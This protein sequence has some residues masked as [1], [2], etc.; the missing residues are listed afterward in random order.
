MTLHRRVIAFTTGVMAIG[1]IAMSA[2]FAQSPSQTIRVM[3]WWSTLGVFKG[4]WEY[5]MKE[6]ERQNPGVRIDYTAT[7]YDQTLNQ[8]MASTLANNA[9][10]MIQVSAVWFEQLRTAN[11]LEPLER[12]IPAEELK[13]FPPQLLEDAKVGGA[14]YGLP[15]APGPIM[16]I[17]NKELLQEAG[18]NP[19]EPPKTW[20]ALTDA[21]RR[22][23]AL[24]ARANGK[25]YGVALRTE[26]N[27]LSAMWAIPMIWSIGGNITDSA[28][29]VDVTNAAAVAAFRW[30][31]DVTRSG[32][33][34][35]G[36]T[37]PEG[38]TIFGQ[39]RAGF[40]FEGPWSRGIFQ[41]IS[42]GRLKMA[43]DGNVWVAPM[44]AGPDGR[45]RLLANHN[46]I[47]MTRQAR[48]KELTAKLIRFMVSD[49]KVAEEVYK[50]SDML[51]T[52]RLDLLKS[53][54]QGDDQYGQVFVRYLNDTTAVPIR[55][56]RWAAGMDAISASMQRIMQGAEPNAELAL[57]QR[58]ARRLMGMQ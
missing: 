15:Q 3:G 54:P 30:Y 20:D 43:P 53:G 57:A 55:N 5:T 16:M 9:P 4:G 44:P 49:P 42:G 2:A 25:V 38:R 47:T 40:I 39:G 51:S 29:R 10:D 32:C 26:R 12:Y 45:V 6:F 33:N 35:E 21:I 37:V 27:P 14:L 24:P 1:A 58:E 18:L 34:P 23:C 46:Y 56:A 50:A 31:H 41:Q 8:V 19:N 48:N 36:A 17:Y 22:V 28:G 11:A 7:A 13:L 52:G